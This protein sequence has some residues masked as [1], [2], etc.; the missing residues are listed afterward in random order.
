MIKIGVNIIFGPF[1][2][3][4]VSNVQATIRRRDD[5]PISPTWWEKQY[6]KNV[7]FGAQAAAVEVYPPE[8]KTVDGENHYHLWLVDYD[9]IPNFHNQENSG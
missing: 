4:R 1:I 6:I 9:S 5:E 2:I 8:R 3:E 7:V